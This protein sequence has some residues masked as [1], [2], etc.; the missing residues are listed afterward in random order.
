MDRRSIRLSR[1]GGTRGH[2]ARREC[3]GH[4]DDQLLGQLVA[5]HERL[6]RESDLRDRRDDLDDSGLPATT[7]DPSITDNGDGTGTLAFSTGTG[8]VIERAIPVA[9]F[10]AEISLSIDLLDLDDITYASNPFRFGSTTAGGG[11]AF[12]VSKRFEYGRLFFSNAHG[13]ELRGLPVP[14]RAQRYDGTGFADDAS[15]SCSSIPLA[16]VSI[17]PSTPSLAAT[18]SIAHDPLLLGDA[19]FELSTPNGRGYFD[20]EVN[21]GP[22]G[23]NLPW[24]RYDWNHDG[25]LDGIL[26]D[27]PQSRATFG[28][29][30][31]RSN[32]IYQQEVH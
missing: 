25:N 32:L 2:A 18:P 27:D 28:I 21:L 29:W 20:L 24:L 5:G 3:G 30:E 1:R 11:I 7:T 23:A 4:D 22:S 17:T 26:D 19:G 15:D 14:L 8:L 6:A 13:S 16:A 10:D 9:P 31:G 12:D